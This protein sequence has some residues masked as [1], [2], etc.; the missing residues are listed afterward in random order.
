MNAVSV[1]KFIKSA[2]EIYR[3]HPIYSKGYDGLNGK[4]DEIGFVRGSLLR[5]GATGVKN[6]KDV[7]KFARSL[8]IRP[9]TGDVNVGDIVF[10]KKW[11][12]YK[13]VGIISSIHPLCAMYMSRY[14]VC[15][16]SNMSQWNYVA[17]VPYV[18]SN[19]VK[20]MIVKDVNLYETPSFGSDSIPIKK[21]TVVSAEKENNVW[22]HVWGD[23]I[24]GYVLTK[25]LISESAK[26]ID[27]AE[28]EKAY[29]II[30]D[31]IS[32]MKNGK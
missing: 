24:S 12:K 19:G 2:Y 21:G 1:E 8:D 11:R 20:M 28:L 17:N 6:M 22:S 5:S 26:S 18:D 3:L 31:F 9:I 4:C 30:G 7:N 25:F 32:Q 29:R 14:G 16:D 10:Q 15:L 13:R 27:L 23:G